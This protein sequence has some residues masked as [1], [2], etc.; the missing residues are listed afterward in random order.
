MLKAYKYKIYSGSKQRKLHELATISGYIYNHCIALHKRYYRLY[1]KHLSRYQLQKHIGKLRKRN[2]KW[3]KLG[4]QAVQ[5]I[6]YRIELAYQSFYSKNIKRPPTFKK[7]RKYKSF[8]FTQAGYKLDRNSIVINSIKT[9][10]SFHYSR[11][12]GG[13]VKNITFKRDALGDF[14]VILICETEN[15][16]KKIKTGRTAGF[17]FGLKTFLT[18]S[19]GT[20]IHSPQ[21]F[22]Q[23]ANAVAKATCNLSRKKK[24]SRNWY[25]AKANLNRV[26]RKATN[27]R[28]DWQWKVANELVSKYDILCFEDLNLDGMKRLWGRKISDL[29]FYDFMQKLECIANKH[30]KQIQKIDRFFPSSKLHMDCGHVN[31]VTLKDRTFACQGCGKILHRDKNAAQNIHRQ[32]I[33]DYARNCKTPL[34]EQVSLVA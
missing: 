18:S 19:D 3:E 31:E 25:R 5:M 26:Y 2:P 16:T 7:S 23:N 22:K 15:Q 12:Y 8:T 24:G 9:K 21:F 6:V 4:S 10:F 28:N 33:A 13:K 29:G 20:E 34:L 14:Y 27:Q 1:G 11:P 30:G 17:D 32:G